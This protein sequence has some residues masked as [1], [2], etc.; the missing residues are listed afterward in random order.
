MKN[1]IKMLFVVAMALSSL[2]GPLHAEETGST[3]MTGLS[4]TVLGGYVN[5]SMPGNLTAEV[6]TNVPVA[7]M[8]SLKAKRQQMIARFK[9]AY[10]SHRCYGGNQQAIG[11]QALFYQLLATNRFS[12]TTFTFDGFAYYDMPGALSGQY[13]TLLMP[14]MQVLRLTKK[15]LVKPVSASAPA[16]PPISPTSGLTLSGGTLTSGHYGSVDFGQTGSVSISGSGHS[17]PPGFSFPALPP[18]LSFPTLNPTGTNGDF[19]TIRQF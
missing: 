3:V 9:S 15:Q 4:S 13:G 17:L 2:V 6:C 18:E 10:L 11:T 1:S 7:Y 12:S 5:T 8:Q 16:G 14:N 19:I